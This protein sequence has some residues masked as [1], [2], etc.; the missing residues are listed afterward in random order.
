[1]SGRAAG[2]VVTEV[3]TPTSALDRPAVRG[4]VPAAPASSATTN[5]HRSGFQMNPVRGGAR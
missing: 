5:D 1:V 3:N 2:T 4:S